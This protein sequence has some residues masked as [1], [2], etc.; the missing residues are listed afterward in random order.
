MPRQSKTT[1][2]PP[3]IRQRAQED[4]KT[5]TG[6]PEPSVQTNTGLTHN[7]LEKALVEMEKQAEEDG[8]VGSLTVPL[9]PTPIIERMR[10]AIV[11]PLLSLHLRR[12]GDELTDVRNTVHI[13]S[14]ALV[15][16]GERVVIHVYREE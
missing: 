1:K 6:A 8:G 16:D 11:P 9:D 10:Q 15:K 4:D 12:V 3:T 14:P 5:L 13:P 2:T 7:D